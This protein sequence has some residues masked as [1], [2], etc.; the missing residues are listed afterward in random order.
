VHCR[1]ELKH[2][3]TFQLEP[4]LAD[5]RFYALVEWT[6]M[7]QQLPWAILFFA[8]GGW[9]WLV[10]GI[11]VRVSVCVTGHWLIGHFSHRKGGQSWRRRTGIQCRHR[12]ADQHG[13]K[14]AQQPSR[15]S[16]LG[17]AGTFPGEIDLGWRLIRAFEAAGLA[18]NVRT[19]DN[20]P[21]RPGL[22]RLSSQQDADVFGTGNRS[23][24]GR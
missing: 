24:A 1:L 18:T 10:W 17:E 16:G 2:P 19:P 3:P 21:L 8:I 22:R 23:G 12:R 6:W 9:S 15:L 5:N 20:L 14:L 11:L 13:R 4:R 7:W